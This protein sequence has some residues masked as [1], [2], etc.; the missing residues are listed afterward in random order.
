MNRRRTSDVARAP[1]LCLYRAGHFQRATDLGDKRP[2]LRGRRRGESREVARSETNVCEDLVAVDVEV[3]E[4]LRLAVEATRALLR[5]RVER[6]DAVEE[7][8]QRVEV[9]GPR[10]PHVRSEDPRPSGRTRPRARRRSR[11]ASRT[12]APTPAA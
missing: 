3:Q 2:L 6:A 4:G 8:R 5:E 7:R 9:A 10:V 11:R 1:A 12:P